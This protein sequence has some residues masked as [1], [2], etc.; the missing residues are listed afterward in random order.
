MLIRVG[1]DV[2]FDLPA[3]TAMLMMLNLHPSRLPTV[4]QQESVRVEPDV[5][6]LQYTDAF[7]NTCGR[8]HAPAGTLRLSNDAVVE[9]TGYPDVM[10]F[11]AVRHP[12][13]Q[14]PPDVLPFLLASR[15]CEVDLL[16]DTAWQLFSHYPPDWSLAHAICNFVHNHLTFG[17]QYARNTRTASEGY[18]ERVGVCRD[19]THLAVTLS[20][21][22][23]IPARYVTGYL[24]DIGI[25]PV[26]APMDFSAWYEVYL[27]G[28][29][30]TMDARHNT[31]RIGRVLMARGRDATD[32]AL[33][34]AFGSA[35][36]RKF[37]VW[38]DEVR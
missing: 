36:L 4:R 16:K 15:Y 6:V 1:F 10:G 14:L 11:G 8:L 13:E 20:R 30:W 12:I 7:G 32:V 29:W 9:D 34:T 3:P 38:T 26:P 22:M 23:N 27:G 18:R 24:G 2:V 25:P 33:T 5:P 37:V 28:K 21:C 17:Y 19:F 35:N 31:P